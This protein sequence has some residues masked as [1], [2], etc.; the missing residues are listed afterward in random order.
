MAKQPQE[1][2][3]NE[4]MVRM[5]AKLERQGVGFDSTTGLNTNNNFSSYARSLKK[6]EPDTVT[7]WLENPGQYAKEL[8]DLSIFLTHSN[9]LYFRAVRYMSS[10]AQICPVLTPT[11]I[12]GTPKKMQ[13]SY[14]KAATLLNVLNL[15]HE[16]VKIFETLFTEAVFY[17]L[18]YRTE[19]SF[20]IKKLNPDYCQITSVNDGSYC[21]H[22]NLSFFDGDKS[23][24]LLES[25]DSIVPIFKSAY[26]TYKKNNVMKW[27]EI[28]AENSACFKIGEGLEH[29]VPPFV[30]AFG[31]LCNLESYKSLNMISTEQNNYQL[32]GLEM[33]TNNKSDKA[34]D[35]KVSADVAMSFY[36]MISSGLPS[37]VGA[38]ISPLKA[39]PIKFDKRQGDIDQVANAT[40]ALYQSLGLS[41]V[42][43]AGATNAGTL[44]YSTRV[45][46]SL[47]FSIYRQ[48]ER[49]LN[50]KMK[51]EGFDYQVT[52]LNATVFT[53]SE[54]Q[55]ELLKL[56]QASVP[57]K[58]HLAAISGL[59]PLEMAT[60]HYLE[61]TILDFENNWI[62]LA[63]SHTQSSSD[64]E[65]GRESLKD[66]DLSDS[67]ASTRDT[68]ANANREGDL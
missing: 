45:D 67:G 10:M 46:E 66:E 17:G 52:L 32:L 54:L 34:N 22:F 33:E 53:R 14:L 9:T 24:A 29:S 48:I 13:D 20:Y 42:L 8:R 47:I 30:S 5:F 61:T 16:T 11:K 55:D 62:P 28:P 39:T 56:S 26:Q 58:A 35:F 41:S 18:E 25:Y 49:W 1:L 40:E 3:I 12:A 68:D 44:K 27:V 59:S 4:Q 36:D 38:F 2:P 65:A 60:T 15:P 64:S 37:G 23:G 43:F 31:D 51:F 21:F 57:V 7:T 63:S 19:D 50:R 6:Y